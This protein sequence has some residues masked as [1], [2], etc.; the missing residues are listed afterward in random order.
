M[1]RRSDGYAPAF[2]DSED[3]PGRIFGHTRMV[4]RERPLSSIY[5]HATS[6]AL[7]I[8]SQ[9]Q[10]LYYICKVQHF[11]STARPAPDT[12]FETFLGR[13]LNAVQ[14]RRSCSEAPLV[15]QQAV[16][17]QSSRTQREKKRGQAKFKKC[18]SY[19]GFWSLGHLRACIP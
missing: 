17:S 9:Y 16:S 12:Y 4:K 5:L 7:R 3:A 14:A 8:V 10:G 18:Y 15:D 19:L 11:R 1:P 13:S 6:T 2:L